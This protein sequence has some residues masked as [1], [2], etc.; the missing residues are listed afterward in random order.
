MGVAIQ[1]CKPQVVIERVSAGQR[2]VAAPIQVRVGG[3]RQWT[4]LQANSLGVGACVQSHR[5]RSRSAGKLVIPL[6][7]VVSE[8]PFHALDPGVDE[9]HVTRDISGGEARIQ[10]GPRPQFAPLKRVGA[11]RIHGRVI[12]GTG[13]VPVA[14]EVG[15]EKSRYDR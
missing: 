7:E 5:T 13:P 12:E 11:E 2:Q 14:S 10:I 6:L 4:D 8:K 9:H 15:M 1:D 3:E